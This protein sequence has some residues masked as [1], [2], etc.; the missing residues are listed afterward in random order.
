MYILPIIL[1]KI[2]VLNKFILFLV[3]IFDIIKVK[4]KYLRRKFFDFNK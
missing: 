4:Y 2:K 3:K 1:E